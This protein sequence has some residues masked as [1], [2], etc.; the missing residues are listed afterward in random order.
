MELTQQ[1]HELIAT[2]RR[3]ANEP[4]PKWSYLAIALPALAVVFAGQIWLGLSTGNWTYMLTVITSAV[5]FFLSGFLV[6]S[7]RGHM[8]IRDLSALLSRS[9]ER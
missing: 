4:D 7:Y 2:A 1:E 9:I 8:V 5:V 6:G 3:K